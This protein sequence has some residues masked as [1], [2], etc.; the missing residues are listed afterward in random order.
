MTSCI[1]AEHATRRVTRARAF[2]DVAA[3]PGGEAWP[4]PNDEAGI[5]ALIA[6]L[7]A[8]APALVVLEATGGLKRLRRQPW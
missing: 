3:R 8:L 5:A 2:L 6:R 4:V 7:V 1:L